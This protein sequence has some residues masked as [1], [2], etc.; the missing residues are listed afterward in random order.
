M[1]SSPTSSGYHILIDQIG[2]LLVEGRRKAAQSVNTILVK[3]Y[4]E[5]GRYIVEY[6]QK[7][8]ER[9]EYGTQLFERLSKDLTLQYGKGFSRSNL[10]YIRKLYLQ[11]QKRETVSHILTWSHYFEIL[12]SDSDLEISFYANQCEKE[13]N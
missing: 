4:W 12:K 5:I 11:F 8:N 10:E 7:G 3:T 1:E 9:D 2:H 6:E 13:T